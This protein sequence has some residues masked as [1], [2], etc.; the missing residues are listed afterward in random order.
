VKGQPLVRVTPSYDKSSWRSTAGCHVGS[1]EIETCVLYIRCTLMHKN[2]KRVRLCK[3]VIVFI[4]KGSCQ[5][6]VKVPSVVEARLASSPRQCLTQQGCRAPKRC[7]VNRLIRGFIS[8]R[9]TMITF[10]YL[11]ASVLALSC[12]YR[13]MSHNHFLLKRKS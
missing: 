4:I 11:F 2:A 7:Q 1:W 8:P 6:N 9:I 12:I 3:L 10:L 13:S 5:D